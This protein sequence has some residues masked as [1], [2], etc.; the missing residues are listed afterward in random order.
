[1]SLS[2]REA[3]PEDYEEL[4]RL[5]TDAYQEFAETLGDDWEGYRDDLADIARRAA[6]GSQ[7]VAETE[8]RPVGTVTYYPPREDEPTASEWWWWPKGF[9]Y[10]RALGVDP[11]T[12]GRGVGRA[13][14]IACIERAR[15]DGA[16]G[17]A[18]NTLSFMPAATALYEGLGFRQTGGNVE[19]GGRK[20]LSYIQ[21]IDQIS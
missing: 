20:L 17:I 4:S 10:L 8:E 21:N 6:Q 12:R 9:A 2:I 13:L 1:M 19:W 11:A 18:L 5:I 7:L 14:T 16:A 15:A 3:V